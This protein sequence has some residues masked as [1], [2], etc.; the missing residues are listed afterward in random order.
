[1]RSSLLLPVALLLVTG[2]LPRAQERETEQERA[3]AAVKKL[4]GTIT[5]DDK[6]PGKPLVSVDL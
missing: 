1:M 5:L 6:N 3:I 4:G 2:P